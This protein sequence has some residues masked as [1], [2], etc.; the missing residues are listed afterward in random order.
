M[1]MLLYRPGKEPSEVEIEPNVEAL[2]QV[3]GTEQYEWMTVRMLKLCVIHD[4][5]GKASGHA[6]NRLLGMTPIYGDFL[7]CGIDWSDEGDTWPVGLVDKQ[8]QL[9]TEVIFNKFP[10]P[11]NLEASLPSYARN[12]KKDA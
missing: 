5:E 4:P 9:V 2:S 10:D 12:R 6:V 11:N 7:V 1:R 3:L 8:V